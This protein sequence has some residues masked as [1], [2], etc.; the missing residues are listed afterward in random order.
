MKPRSRA[1]QSPRLA[2][3]WHGPGHWLLLLLLL[4]LMLTAG[5]VQAFTRPAG[6]PA[7]VLRQVAAAGR[8]ATPGA[9]STL[10]FFFTLPLPPRLRPASSVV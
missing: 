6:R 8:Y 7:A 2:K 9:T 10:F 4:L 1:I 5:A 3:L